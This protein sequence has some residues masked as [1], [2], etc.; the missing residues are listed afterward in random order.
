[1]DRQKMETKSWKAAGTS[2]AEIGGAA[3]PKEKIF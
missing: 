2:Y 1:M 3:T